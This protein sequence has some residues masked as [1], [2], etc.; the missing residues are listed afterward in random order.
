MRRSDDGRF[1]QD[2][3]S[4]RECLADLGAAGSH[5]SVSP[6]PVAVHWVS[7]S[8][9]AWQRRD[10]ARLLE[11][12]E[13]DNGPGTV[14]LV[15]PE[16][17]RHWAAVFDRLLESDGAGGFTLG[18]SR[19]V[20]T[21]FH[22]G[23]L[24][25]AARSA[26]GTLP[27]RVRSLTTESFAAEGLKP[28]DV[29]LP[30]SLPEAVPSKAT[31]I[32]LPYAPRARDS[33]ATAGDEVWFVDALFASDGKIPEEAKPIPMTEM[34][35]KAEVAR[36]EVRVWVT[37]A[38]ASPTG[39]EESV[40]FRVDTLDPEVEVGARWDN[41]TAVV[42]RVIP[43][44]DP[45][46][47]LSDAMSAGVEV[48]APAAVRA[49]LPWEL[50]GACRVWSEVPDLD[51][52]QLVDDVEASDSDRVRRV[53]VEN[54]HDRASRSLKRM[55][56]EEGSP[57]SRRALVKRAKER[58]TEG[59]WSAAVSDL[60]TLADAE[61]EVATHCA[62]LGRAY[63][64]LGAP[65]L[66]FRAYAEA[67]LL[68]PT[69][70]KIRSKYH[71][72]GQRLGHTVTESEDEFL[73]RIAARPDDVRVRISYAEWLGARGS[74]TRALQ[75][76]REARDLSDLTA[77][78]GRSIV[79]SQCDLH[80][81]RGDDVEVEPICEEVFS[82]DRRHYKAAVRS[83][84]VGCRLGRDAAELV[85]RAHRAK[86]IVSTGLLRRPDPQSSR[87]QLE[88]WVERI[89]EHDAR[90]AALDA[91]P[92]DPVAQFRFGEWLQAAHR[93]DEAV[94]LYESARAIDPNVI[95]RAV[96]LAADVP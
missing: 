4:L 84:I 22:G 21:W 50:R 92:D 56:S 95:E 34:W 78:E 61:P 8:L 36:T 10:L 1:V 49:Q 24:P 52:A 69:D 18:G 89:L 39:D 44:L 43:R 27:V 60:C 42:L 85:A 31:V 74:K 82:R 19:V 68:D 62:R 48:L 73:E 7:S 30:R 83:V 70:D 20:E 28:G 3:R 55:G 13:S 63:V 9:D 40:G 33:D 54:L 5:P 11:L 90:R 58:F 93:F 23:T 76:M 91:A 2:D 96:P 32:P 72:L 37:S 26:L 59:E 94:D 67:I 47:F 38:E 29:W 51:L 57:P 15:A 80:W 86:P 45:T 81:E 35:Q 12:L 87:A 16:Y 71:Q 77:D 79:E 14:T 46:V 41:V 25:A 53:A 17:A 6:A 75:V 66:G 65:E 88:R 64:E